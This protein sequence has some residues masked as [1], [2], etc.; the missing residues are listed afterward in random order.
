M[1]SRPAIELMKVA[2]CLISFDLSIVL[3]SLKLVSVNVVVLRRRSDVNILPNFFY[4]F[5]KIII[6]INLS[7][8]V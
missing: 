6:P 4:F 1:L 8:D 2:A 7:G 5:F 3:I